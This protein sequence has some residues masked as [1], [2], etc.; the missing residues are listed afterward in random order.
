M[1]HLVRSL[2]LHLTSK[3]G[4]SRRFS[5]CGIQSL[6]LTT[7]TE[8]SILLL[9]L[10][11]A[12]KTTFL[13]QLKSLYH[14]GPSPAPEPAKKTIPTVGQ[15][16]ATLNFP[17]MYLKIWDV[18][19]QTSLRGLW[20]SYYKSCH[21]IIFI[22]DSTDIGS[23]D[24][25]LADEDE[26][27]DGSQGKDDEDGDGRE[28]TRPTHNRRPSQMP[29]SEQGR[30]AECRAVLEAVLAEPEAAGVPVLI[31]ANKQDL[32]DSVEVIKIKEGL[33][34][35][36]FEGDRGGAIRDSRVLP[37]S[38]LNGTGVKEAVEWVRKRVEGN[39]E[40]RPGVLR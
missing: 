35:L 40:M 8:Y 4:M 9:G 24:N 26:D 13:S 21:A 10:D 23:L 11:N 2:Y 36:V 22:V 12:G 27:D 39:K 17:D 16:V 29:E 37:C 32:E 6:D 30:L 18:G 38:A 33:V 5:S 20:K 28:H 15:N 31:L 25:V 19:G 1:Y 7:S 34:Q 3:E 14:T